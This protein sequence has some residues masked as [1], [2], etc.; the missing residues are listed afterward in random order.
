[1]PFSIRS[2][3]IFL[4]LTGTA[5]LATNLLSLTLE[6]PQTLD[7]EKFKGLCYLQ[8]S[9]FVIRDWKFATSIRDLEGF[10]ICFSGPAPQYSYSGEKRG[11]FERSLGI[12]EGDDKWED[13]TDPV[14]K[15]VT[16]EE[17]RVTVVRTDLLPKLVLWNGEDI[18]LR[19]CDSEGNHYTNVASVGLDGINSLWSVELR[20]IPVDQTKFKALR[21]EKE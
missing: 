2:G 11:F 6:V 16:R 19:L 8:I 12:V 18:T 7:I 14:T 15:V 13:I 4:T 3:D 5:T 1:M 10:H 17:R 20:L 9:E 21:G